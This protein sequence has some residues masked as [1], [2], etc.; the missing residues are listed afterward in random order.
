MAQKKE[1][2]GLKYPPT[3]KPKATSTWRRKP[4]QVRKVDY[5]ALTKISELTKSRSNSPQNIFKRSLAGASSNFS[6][7]SV[8][9]KIQSVNI[10]IK[11]LANNHQ[12]EIG[13]HKNLTLMKEVKFEPKPAR[14]EEDDFSSSQSCSNSSQS[15]AS[16]KSFFNNPK[17]SSAK[18]QITDEME[19]LPENETNTLKRLNSTDFEERKAEDHQGLR[20][21]KTKFIF[22][23]LNKA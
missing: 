2:S 15:D 14:L 9:S 21:F 6:P 10:Q 11:S 4:E 1:S 23:H 8:N 3:S 22:G 20:F 5:G 7:K 19:G 17:K 18:D 12:T 16:F 13:L